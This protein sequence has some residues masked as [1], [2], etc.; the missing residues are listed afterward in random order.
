MDGVRIS[1]AGRPAPLFRD[2]RAYTNG[3]SRTGRATARVGA[4]ERSQKHAR[5][6]PLDSSRTSP[7][8]ASHRWAEARG[9]YELERHT[10]ER[11]QRQRVN[12]GRCRC[13][14]GT[15]AGSGRPN[16]N[17]TAVASFSRARVGRSVGAELASTHGCGAGSMDRWSKATGVVLTAGRF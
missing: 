12:L 2:A 3:Q 16:T 10:P 13:R 6:W 7:L 11:R 4:E 17:Q 14:H 1:P 8:S 5:P 15:A 9:T